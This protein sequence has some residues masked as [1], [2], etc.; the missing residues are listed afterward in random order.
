[1]SFVDL[2]VGGILW[3][4]AWHFTAY[5]ID[6]LVKS[7]QW[8][9]ITRLTVGVTSAYPLVEMFTART[10]AMVGADGATIKQHRATLFCSYFGAF[11][12]YGIGKV[13]ATA[14]DRGKR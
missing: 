4:A 11:V 3:G 1:M 9:Y 8:N 10:A 2:F 12:A 13:V 14:L 6:H 7:Q 5:P